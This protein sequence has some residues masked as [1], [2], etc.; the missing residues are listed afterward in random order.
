MT[1]NFCSDSNVTPGKR[2]RA[3][4][5]PVMRVCV[6]SRRAAKRVVCTTRETGCV[7]LVRLARGQ[8]V[9]RALQARV[10]GPPDWVAT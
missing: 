2:S 3:P 1:K 5:L 6:V 7:A 10:I 4:R 9:S 8:V